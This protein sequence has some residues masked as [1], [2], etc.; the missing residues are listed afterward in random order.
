MH[1]FNFTADNLANSIIDWFNMVVQRAPGVIISLLVGILIVRILARLTRF[2]LSFTTL[3]KG[4]RQIISSA[5]ETLLW[6]LLTILIMQELGFSNI[7]VFFSSS[8]LAIGILLAAGGSTL[9]S[10]LIAGIFLAGDN[11]FNIGDEVTLGENQTQGIIESMDVRRVRLRDTDGRLHVLPNSLVERKEW[12]VIHKRREITTL[13]KATKAAQRLQQVAI[14]K[15]AR[16]RAKK[17]P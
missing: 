17:S 11:D 2:F 4:L 5:I 7:L 9:L 12:V 14:E 16:H 1:A 8:T 6:L 3:Q 13:A 15:A 10:D